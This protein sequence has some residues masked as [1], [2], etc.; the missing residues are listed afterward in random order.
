M[1]FRFH[2]AIQDFLVSLG[3]KDTY[4]LV[5]LAG[6]SK[7]LADQDSTTM[8]VLLKQVELSQKLHKISEVYLIHHMDCGAYGGHKAFPNEQV[9]HDR[10]CQD[11]ETSQSVLTRAFPELQIKK[12]LAR[13]TEK[14]GENQIDFKV[15]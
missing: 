2:T 1:D 13:I 4:D 14:D 8:P 9:E 5:S 15:I 7:C 10:Q 11:M 6:V 12:V 3:L